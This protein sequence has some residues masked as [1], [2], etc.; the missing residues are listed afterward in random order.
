MPVCS[1]IFNCTLDPGQQTSISLHVCSVIDNCMFSIN[2]EFSCLHYGT[3]LSPVNCQETRITSSSYSV[4]KILVNTLNTLRYL[5]ALWLLY[6]P[7]VI[8]SLGN[9]GK[10]FYYNTKKGFHG[11]LNPSTICI[12]SDNELIFFLNQ[13]TI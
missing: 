6:T 13:L 7:C 4:N 10:M 12:K 5:V 11:C 2:V 1:I 9:S 3:R 8:K